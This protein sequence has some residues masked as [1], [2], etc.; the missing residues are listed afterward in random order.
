MMG[1]IKHKFPARTEWR[2]AE[3]VAESGR[4]HGLLRNQEGLT[5]IEILMAIGVLGVGLLGL[6]AALFGAVASSEYSKAQ[7]AAL[8]DAK[9]VLEQLRNLDPSGG[10]GVANTL[11][12]VANNINLGAQQPGGAIT[13]PNGNQANLPNE[14]CM[15]D[16]ISPPGGG[17]PQAVG[18]LAG[19]LA[20]PSVNPYEIV[21]TIFWTQ[22]MRPVSV[23]VR[24]AGNIL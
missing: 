7:S 23:T 10:V 12:D 16:V 21:V 3:R 1:R 4:R 9:G 24:T 17:G 19:A 18:V 13:I 22:G 11:L 6:T 14:F 15:V 20:T 8:Q 5:L 2:R